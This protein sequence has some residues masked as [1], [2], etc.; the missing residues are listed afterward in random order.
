M[1][2][3]WGGLSTVT[4]QLVLAGAIQPDG[5]FDRS[6]ML[7]HAWLWD[8]WFDAWGIVLV[9]GLVR[10][11]RGPSRHRSTTAPGATDELARD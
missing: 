2:I 3:L 9:I 5:G 1:L 6:S 7:G 11:R 10:S 8:P 4:A